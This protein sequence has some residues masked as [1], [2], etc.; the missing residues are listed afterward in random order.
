M[1]N[2]LLTGICTLSKQVILGLYK[3]LPPKPS[4]I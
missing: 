3:D 1:E 2:M 4:E